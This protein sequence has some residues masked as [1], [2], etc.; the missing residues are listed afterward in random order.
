MD[1]I[2]KYSK[3]RE[4]KSPSMGTPNSAGIDVFI[5]NEFEKIEFLPNVSVKVPTGLKFN[6]PEGYALI[7]YNKSGIASK[8]NLVLGACVIDSDYQG[9]VIVNLH[10]IGT[11]T[12]TLIGG[13]PISQ[14]L[15]KKVLKMDLIETDFTELY[16]KP[17]ER[18]EGGFGSTF[19]V[20]G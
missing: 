10:N 17:T 13:D 14:L 18:G 15:I 12:Q 5:P 3:I 16:D 1:G 2:I 8:K 7:F 9:E 19:E 11:E 20:R 6:I 4:V